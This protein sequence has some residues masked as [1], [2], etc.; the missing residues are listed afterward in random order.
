MQLLTHYDKM[1][2]TIFEE[3]T[4]EEE[5][6][7]NIKCN[8]FLYGNIIECHTIIV[9]DDSTITMFLYTT[10][11]S[12]INQSSQVDRFFCTLFWMIVDLETKLSEIMQ[13]E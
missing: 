4:M 8:M 1:F 12:T 9:H 7:S 6:E 13:I 11:T 2:H 5:L 3:K 10:I